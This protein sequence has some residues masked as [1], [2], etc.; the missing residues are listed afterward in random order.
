M[1]SETEQQLAILEELIKDANLDKQIKEYKSKTSIIQEQKF[2][3]LERLK[4][5][6]K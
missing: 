2:A 4:S 6:S 1:L 5:E 3:E